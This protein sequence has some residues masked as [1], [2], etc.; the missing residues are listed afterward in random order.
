MKH[1]ITK[2]TCGTVIA[3]CRCPA[4]DKVLNV[5]QDGCQQCQRLRLSRAIEIEVPKK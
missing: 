4:T 2:C 3:Q 5:I 1:F